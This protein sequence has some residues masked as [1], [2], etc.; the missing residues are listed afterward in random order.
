MSPA[1]SVTMDLN[2]KFLRFCICMSGNHIDLI[3]LVLPITEPSNS[4]SGA[5]SLIKRR[6]SVH[7]RSKYSSKVMDKEMSSILL[8]YDKRLEALCYL[9]EQYIAGIRKPKVLGTIQCVQ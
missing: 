1:T 8:T 6:L 2:W 9:G 4:H 3:K 5:D 7:V